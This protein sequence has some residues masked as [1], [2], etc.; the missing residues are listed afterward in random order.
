VRKVTLPASVPWI[1]TGLV[2][3]MDPV[4]AMELGLASGSLVATGLG[5]DAGL[6]DRSGLESFMA[7]TARNPL[8]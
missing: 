4:G 7:T 8:P 5:S 1:L 6:T 3:G 2:E